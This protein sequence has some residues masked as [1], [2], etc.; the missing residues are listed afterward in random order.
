MVL[1]FFVVILIA[2]V[3]YLYKGT[4]VFHKVNNLKKRMKGLP[5]SGPFAAVVTDIEGWTGGGGKCVAWCRGDQLLCPDRRILPVS[6]RMIHEAAVLEGAVCLLCASQG[7][8][9]H[10]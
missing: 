4:E 5:T 2:G 7:G 1:G 10:N 8:S 6:C 9:G 3:F